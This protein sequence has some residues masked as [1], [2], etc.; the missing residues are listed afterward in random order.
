MSEVQAPKASLGNILVIGGCGF[1][2]HHIVRQLQETY[3][4]TPSVIDLKTNK[5]RIADVSYHDA[6]ITSETQ[7]RSLFETLKPQVV[8]H[9]ASP[10]NVTDGSSSKQK[11][12]AKSLMQKVNVDGTKNLLK[13]A[14]EVGTVKGFVYTSSASVIHDNATDLVNA[15]EEWPVLFAP[16]QKDYYSDTK[17][18]AETLVLEANR[19][20]GT[21]LTTSLRPAGIFGEGD[22]QNIPNFI[23]ACRKRQT[24]FQLGDNNNLFD[25]TYVG[26]VAHAHI[27]AAIAL[28]QTHKLG[29]EPLDNERVDGEAF[30]ITNGEPIYFWDYARTIWRLAGDKTELT[31]VWHLSR[32]NSMLIAAVIETGMWLVGQVPNLTAQKVNYSSLTRYYNIKKARERLGYRPLVDLQAGLERTVNWFLKEEIAKGEKKSQ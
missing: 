28:L 9:T 31:S 30:F 2:G 18:Q 1:L 19:K 32:E 20:N 25:F 8:I 16:E 14:A 4:C 11:R 21:M 10:P 5:N 12:S 27:L 23:K 22:A 17:A 13:Q 3:T 15:N 24:N 6:D 29:T 7:I 26:N